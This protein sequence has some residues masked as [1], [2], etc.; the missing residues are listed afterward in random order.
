MAIQNRLSE[1][2]IGSNADKGTKISPCRMSLPF[3]DKYCTDELNTGISKGPTKAN[4]KANT[5]TNTKTNKFPALP[6]EAITIS[7]SLN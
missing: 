4:T 1:H 2:E 5:K 7:H 3:R 6:E